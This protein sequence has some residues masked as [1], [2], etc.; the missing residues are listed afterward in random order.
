MFKIRTISI[1]FITMMTLTACNTW[2]GI[3]KDAGDVGDA[4]GEAAE[5]AKDAIHEA[6]E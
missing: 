3:K 6:T 1:L 5:N 2:E 4:V